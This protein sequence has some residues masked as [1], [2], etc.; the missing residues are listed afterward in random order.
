MSELWTRFLCDRTGNSFTPH[1]MKRWTE[2]IAKIHGP[3]ECAIR[4][5]V[6]RRNP[7]QHKILNA[8]ARQIAESTGHTIEEIKAQALVECFGMDKIHELQIRG[9]T[10]HVPASTNDLSK[11][12]ASKVIDWL[13]NT[14]EFLDLKLMDP[15][16]YEVM[17]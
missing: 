11:D 13:K 16:T 6:S 17:K 12:E 7:E 8:T 1:D 15:S 14:A 9:N 4:A 5:A 2:T 3:V 10:Y